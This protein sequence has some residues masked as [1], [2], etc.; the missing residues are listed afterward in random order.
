[1]FLQNCWYVAAWDH[2]VP[3]SGPIGRQVV[4]EPLVLFRNRSNEIRVLADRC[5]HRHAPLSLGRLE[6]GKLR[7]MY[8]GLL[9]DEYGACLSVPGSTVIPPNSKV[10]TYPSVVRDNWVWVWPG[11]PELA[12]PSL[13]PKAFGLENPKL[14]MKADQIDYKANYMLLNDNLCDL[15]HVDF[16]H[17]TTLGLASGGGW[18]DE[19]PKVTLRDRALQFERWFV[20]KPASPTNPKLV[21]TWSTYTYS[22]P[23]IFVMENRSFPHGTARQLSH[24]QPTGEGDTYRVEQQAVTPVSETATRYFFATGFDARIPAKILGGIFDVVMAAFAEDRTIIEAQ[25]AIWNM[26]D[27]HEPMAFI[28]HDKA[29]AMFRRLVAKLLA[30]EAKVG[31]IASD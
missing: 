16:V 5:P 26:T 30:K 31:A 11:D 24:M 1:M 25:Q 7:C 22:V 14:V 19:V 2:E 15:S 6:D 18:S 29:P 8:H 27:S 12:D 17:E 20:G 28:A 21:D 4:G 3:A 13:I 23:G 10:R 9:F